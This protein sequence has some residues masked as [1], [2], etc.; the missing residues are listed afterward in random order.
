MYFVIFSR[1]INSC[2]R[3]LKFSLLPDDIFLINLLSN[4]N[5]NSLFLYSKLYLFKKGEFLRVKKKFRF[6]SLGFFS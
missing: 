2:E 4:N 3:I 6:L 1:F 5:D